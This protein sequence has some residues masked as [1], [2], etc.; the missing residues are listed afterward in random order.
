MERYLN[1]SGSSGVAAY[2]IGED[3]IWVQFTSG[4]IYEYTYS[5]AGT[6]NIE[7][8]KS[9]ANSGS[10]LNSFIMKNVRNKYSRK[11]Q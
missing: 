9:L 3:Y 7:E 10:G 6:R 8:M 4:S 5:S 2:Q 1:H 11:I